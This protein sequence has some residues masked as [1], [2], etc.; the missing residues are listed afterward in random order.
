MPVG[1]NVTQEVSVTINTGFSCI[2]SDV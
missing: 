1:A 2:S